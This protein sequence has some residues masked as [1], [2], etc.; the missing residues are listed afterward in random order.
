[1][2]EEEVK[3]IEEEETEEESEPVEPW[4]SD[5]DPK[6]VP[7]GAHVKAK[8][9]LRGKVERR[10]SRIAELERKLEQYEGNKKPVFTE[11]AQRPLPEDFNSDGD[12]RAALT[13]W[14]DEAFEKRY[15]RVSKQRNQKDQELQMVNSIKSQVDSHYDRAASLLQEHSIDES[16]Y[17][18]ADLNVRSAVES[19]FPGNGDAYV[20]ALIANLGE[21]SE[22]TLYMIGRNKERLNALTAAAAADKTGVKL[23]IFMGQQHAH[24]N[25]KQ[26]NQTR[27]PEPAPD[28]SDG[29]KSGKA[30][31]SSLKKQFDAFHKKGNSAEA[32]KIYS[33]ARRSGVDV[34]EWGA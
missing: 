25:L 23:S 22:K 20:D 30:N 18:K 19:I 9:K 32:F 6:T 4:M 17:Q 1:M 24:A 7:L 34:S 21:G 5:E 16:A 11:T 31:A 14:E 26:K 10:D 28:L 13:R 3:E 2:S 15:N 27:A 29:E 12:Y 33:K 8:H